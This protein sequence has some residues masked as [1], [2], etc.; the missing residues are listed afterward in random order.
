MNAHNWSEEHARRV[1]KGYRQFMTLKARLEDWNATILS[2]SSVVDQIWHL[3]IL[4][5]Q[6]YAADCITLCGQVVHHNV[7]AG[8]NGLTPEESDARRDRRANTRAALLEHFEENEIDKERVWKECFQEAERNE[9]DGVI[10]DVP[11]AEQADGPAAEQVDGPNLQDASVYITFSVQIDTTDDTMM[12]RA[13]P[14]T[15]V[16]KIK[17]YIANR[18]GVDP[19]TLRLLLD[20][21]RLE[22]YETLADVGLQ[23]GDRFDVLFEQCGC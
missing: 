17:R 1:L 6:R 23:D 18:L 5:T 2:P 12:L 3:H 14:T 8:L 13:K 7:D 16:E 10:V 4:D 11:A 19:D 9:Q 20:G 22:F 21:D 15:R